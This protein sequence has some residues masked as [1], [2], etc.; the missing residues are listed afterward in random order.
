M[1]RKLRRTLIR[2]GATVE[3]QHSGHV[4]VHKPGLQPVFL[5]STTA[6]HRAEKNA[7]ALLKREGYLD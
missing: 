6:N 2:S 5:S 7:R 3:K 4:K 1:N